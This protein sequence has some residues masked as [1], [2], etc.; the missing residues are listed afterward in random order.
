[1]FNIDSL[2]SN[3]RYETYNLTV[4]SSLF[5]GYYKDKYLV[6]GDILRKLSKDLGF[7]YDL[8]TTLL[9]ISPE[10]AHSLVNSMSKQSGHEEITL[11]L[12]EEK[13]L[14]YS[15]E[16]PRTP[17]LN[18]D[19]LKRAFSLVEASENVEISET[20]YLP[21]DTIST[22]ILKKVTPVIVEER[23]E[24]KESKKFEYNIGVLVVNDE[25]STTYSRLVLYVNDHP[26][27]LPASYYNSTV[28]RY[29]RSTGSSSEA[30]EVLLLK[31]MEDLRDDELHNKI[32]DLHYR[33][34]S[35][36]N[37]LATYEEFNNVLKTMRRIPTIIEDN[38]CLESLL[39]KYSNFERK[40]VKMEEQKSSYIWRCTAIGGTTIDSLINITTGI[41]NDLLAPSSEY[42]RIRELLGEYLSTGRIA[43]EIAV[44]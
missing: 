39:A 11:L 41:L 40:Y 27:Y 42:M 8:Y 2:K 35:N 16:S 44:E 34:R 33:Y 20:H 38:S 13:V 26:L 28:S 9:G 3:K 31:I 6:T 4:D 14:G 25:L 32:Y 15:L 37:I 5:R 17:L 30:F 23:Y 24:G 7:S 1:M 22:I 12:D 43:T 19:F 10:A 36:K 18:I 21:E 29:K